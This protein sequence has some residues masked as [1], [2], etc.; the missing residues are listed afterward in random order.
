MHNFP[1]FIPKSR[2]PPNSPDLCPLD[3]SLWTELTNCMNWSQITTKAILIDEIKRAVKR[4]GREK[5]LNSV[6]DF[7][8][9]LR[10][11]KN[12]GGEYIR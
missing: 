11:L 8:I 6:S 5:I 1:D 2:W 4:V 9:R 12:N 7:T 10:M 3:Y